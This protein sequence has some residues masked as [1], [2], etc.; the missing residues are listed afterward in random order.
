[1]CPDFWFLVWF[2]FWT[3]RYR[4]NFPPKRWLTFEIL[5]SV[6]FQ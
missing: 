5:H 1:M 6:I 3:W 2:I 4:R